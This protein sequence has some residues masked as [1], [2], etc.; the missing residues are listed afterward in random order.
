M[1]S[2]RSLRPVTI[3]GLALAL[4]AAMLL[5]APSAVRPEVA[6]AQTCGYGYGQ[7]YGSY[8]GSSCYSNPYSTYG[9]GTSTYYCSS[10]YGSYGTYGNYGC[11]TALFTS[12][13]SGCSSTLFSTGCSGFGSAYGGTG[14]CVGQALQAG[15]SCSNGV[16]TCAATTG[17]SVPCSGYGIQ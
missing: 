6:S 10:S 4:L 9:C 17:G 12:G 11:T 13:C 14:S 2:L 15:Q 3:A 8:L 5:A 7:T 1:R 16:I